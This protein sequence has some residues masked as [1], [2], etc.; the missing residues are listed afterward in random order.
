MIETA[1]KVRLSWFLAL[2]WL[3]TGQTALAQLPSPCD[4]FPYDEIPVNMAKS[5]SDVLQARLSSAINSSPNSADGVQ[6]AERYYGEVRLP[7]LTHCEIIF[8]KKGRT[9]TLYNIRQ[10]L[11]RHLL[12]SQGMIHDRLVSTAFTRCSE[13]VNGENYHPAARYNAIL[14]IGTLNSQERSNTSNAVPYAAALPLLMQTMDDAGESM[15][16]KI[17]AMLGIRRF[18]QLNAIP[19]DS[20]SLVIRGALPILMASDPPRGLD[21]KVHRWSRGRAAEVLGRLGKVG[22]N[23]EV[24]AGMDLVLAEPELPAKLACQ[25]A[26]ALGRLDYTGANYDNPSRLATRVMRHMLADYEEEIER[27]QKQQEAF[28]K[29]LLKYY[30]TSAYVAL[31]GPVG[32]SGNEP[33]GLLALA[34]EDPHQEFVKQ[35]I[36]HVKPLFD[37]FDDRNMVESDVK[38]G[39]ELFRLTTLLKSYLDE[40]A[41]P[42]EPPPEQEP[43]ATTAAKDA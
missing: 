22:D 7:S 16:M 11:A 27:A 30:F 42:D 19:E 5:E 12:S 17:G 33:R 32:G 1:R 18:A 34:S 8:S 2:G 23:M 28:V 41:P 10:E 25:I 35:A 15:T 31:R 24:L 37:I 9:D 14:I 6:A 20:T 21:E 40:N 38:L 39:T 29:P 26:D 3:V 13:I 43:V 4:D 36:A